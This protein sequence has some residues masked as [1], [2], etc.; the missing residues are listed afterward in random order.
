MS[1]PAPLTAVIA[2]HTADLERLR[3]TELE[4]LVAQSEINV[5]LLAGAKWDESEILSQIQN[6]RSRLEYLTADGGQTAPPARGELEELRRRAV[7]GHLKAI[8]VLE[9]HLEF[10]HASR[11]VM[12]EHEPTFRALAE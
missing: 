9:E 11:R 12:D 1:A 4:L 7:A 2:A 3:V 5:A 6:F 8:A 10:I